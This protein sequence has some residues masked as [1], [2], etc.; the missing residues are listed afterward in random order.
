MNTGLNELNIAAKKSII[1]RVEA[2]SILSWIYTYYEKKPEVSLE[3]T[4]YLCDEYPV[5]PYFWSLNLKNLMLLQRYDDAEI[6]MDAF[7]I[8]PENE[9]FEAVKSVFKGLIQE[10]KYKNNELAETYYKEGLKELS[11]FGESGNEYS[12]YAFFGLSRIYEYSGDKPEAK[13]CHRKA[14][15]L[16]DFKDINFN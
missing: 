6:S 4:K 15:D 2:N 10:K 5:N 12:A 16:A 8:Y 14:M 9:Y 1:L 3:Y 7:Q 13:K 11:V